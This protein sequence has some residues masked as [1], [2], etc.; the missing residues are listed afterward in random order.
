[1][2]WPEPMLR[3]GWLQ[4]YMMK[5]PAVSRFA[6]PDLGI[7]VGY[8]VAHY[9][10]VVEEQPEMD[11][12][13]VLAENFMVDGGS[14]RHWLSELAKH[15]P[16]VLHGVA[17]SLGGESDPEHLERLAALVTQ[18]RPPWVSDHLC[19]TGSHSANAHD[20]LPLPYTPK[21]RDHV[22]GRIREVSKAVGTLYAVEN[23]SSYLTW[24]AS[25][26]PEWEF[27]TQVVEGA[28]CGILLDVNNVFVSSVNHGFDP[29]EYI[30]NIPLDR[31][32]QIHLAGHSIKDGYRLD[33]HDGPVCDEYGSCTRQSLS[34]WAQCLRSLNGTVMFLPSAAC[35]K[36]QSGLVP[37]AMPR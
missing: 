13:E 23:V 27:L 18:V 36:K 7:G 8:R 31:V 24:K 29:L 14:P 5:R 35:K 22:I 26:V 11:W 25:E 16:L 32:V 4:H 10:Q 19:F 3:Q 30:D 21:V 37:S 2:P 28:D 15:Y 6:V 9:R 17:T 12:F 33:T 20:L 1:M 34:E